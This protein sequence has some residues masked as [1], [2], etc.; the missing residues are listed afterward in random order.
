MRRFFGGRGTNKFRQNDLVKLSEESP[1][2]NLP[3][4]TVGI[5]VSVYTGPNPS[6]EVE[7]VDAR[8]GVMDRL[9]VKEAHLSPI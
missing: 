1:Y 2:S 3:G 8:G 9:V 5:V 6:Y 7:F 4:G